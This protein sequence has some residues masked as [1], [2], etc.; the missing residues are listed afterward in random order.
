M[1]FILVTIA[2]TPVKSLLKRRKPLLQRRKNIFFLK[3]FVKK[4]IKKRGSYF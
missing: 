1:T 2:L 3:H 4:K